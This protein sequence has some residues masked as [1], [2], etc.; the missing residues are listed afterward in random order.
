MEYK[1]TR[2][3]DRVFAGAEV[4]AKGLAEDGG[5]FVPSSLPRLSGAELDAFT[6]ADYRGIAEKIFSLF[7]TDF[8]AEEI[9]DCVHAAYGSNFDVPDAAALLP[10]GKYHV[11]ELWHGPT[12]AFKDMAL[13]ILPHLLTRSVKKC[14]GGKNVKILVATSGDTGKA[15]LEGFKDVDGCSVTVYYP[16][17]GVSGVQKLQM[18]TQ[19]GG[20]VDVCAVKGNFDDCQTAVKQ[21]FTSGDAL[22]KL[23]RAGMTFSSANS[24]NWGR[25]LPQIVYYVYSFARLKAHGISEFNVCVP[26]GNFGNILAAYYAREM[27]VPIRKLICASNRNNVLTDFIN[28]GVYDR[29]RPFYATTSPSMDILIS[30]NLE[31][32]LYHLSDG[33]TALISGLYKSLSDSGKFTVS[34][35]VPDALSKK[36]RTLF[37][38]GYCDEVDTAKT[39]RDT[40]AGTKYLIDTHTATAVK[41]YGD[42]CKSTSD[43]TPTVVVSTASP[44][45]FGTAVYEAVSRET[46]G[47]DDFEIMESLSKLTDTP[48]PPQLSAVRT[49]PV[50]FT[51]VTEKAEIVSEFIN[52]IK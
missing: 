24:I 10:V 15:A 42:Y 4:I 45:K 28:T 6:G 20:N 38:G 5:L 50:R 35:V 40:F 23:D 17:D 33:D 44:Y 26:T 29:N 9:H 7:L 16:A 27:G 21:I 1:S 2:S 8:T 19:A 22:V 32:L 18:T 41:V 47:T 48:V 43:D 36:I 46:A 51:K 39:I 30:S 12:C 14:G 25:L 49:L 11:L 37:Y 34:D 31:R 52:S 13:Q 3:D